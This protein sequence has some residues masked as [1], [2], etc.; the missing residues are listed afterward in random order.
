MQENLIAKWNGYTYTS[1][2]LESGIWDY[3]RRSFTGGTGLLHREVWEHHF[4]PIPDGCDIHHR[5]FD[6]TNNSIENLECLTREDHKKIKHPIS[7]QRAIQHLKH[8]EAIRPLTKAWH[9]SPEGIAK[10]REIG[11]LAYVGF[12]PEPKP[13][14]QCSTVFSPRALGNR[15]LFC[16][17]K[18]KSAWRR[19]SGRDN[20]DRICSPCGGTFTV[21]RYARARTCS[22]TCGQRLRYGSAK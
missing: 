10:H 6:K 8:L 22:R 3:L 20:E 18:C 2:R 16:S 12:V 21:S 13:C 9:A 14:S 4:G 19:V 7:E 1:R 17:N 11:A 15:D 5:D